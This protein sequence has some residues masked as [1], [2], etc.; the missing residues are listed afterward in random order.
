MIS[1]LL[2]SIF[3]MLV[4]VIVTS[5][6]TR[7]AVSYSHQHFEF[8]LQF[9]CL[10]VLMVSIDVLISAVL[11]YLYVLNVDSIQCNCN[12]FLIFSFRMWSSFVQPIVPLIANSTSNFLIGFQYFTVTKKSRNNHRFVE[13]H[14]VKMPYELHA[15]LLNC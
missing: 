9:F 3:T 5:R 2:Y 6:F 7:K 4:I 12:S 10:D 8:F 13:F 15:Y 1:N 14:F 11:F